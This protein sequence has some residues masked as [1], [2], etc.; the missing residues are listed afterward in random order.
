MTAWDEVRKDFPALERHV[1]LNAAAASPTPRPVG[2]AV[3]R[4]YRELE[5]GGDLHWDDWLAGCEA[6]RESVAR[7]IGAEADEIAF[8]PNTSAGINLIADLLYVKL[9]PRVV[10]A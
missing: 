9:D 6:A 1:Y 5:Q 8:V 2:E 7:L 4:F 10:E 3:A